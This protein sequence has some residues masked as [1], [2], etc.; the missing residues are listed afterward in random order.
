MR[1]GCSSLVAGAKAANAI[2]DGA[3]DVAG[4]ETPGVEAIREVLERGRK[5]A[6]DEVADREDSQP[7]R[8]QEIVQPRAAAEAEE[9]KV[10]RGQPASAAVVSI[11]T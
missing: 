6:V 2:I 11:A 7:D 5:R 1:F 10:C 3:E 4:R 8:Q 9:D